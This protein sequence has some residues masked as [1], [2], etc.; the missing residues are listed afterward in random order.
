MIYIDLPINH[1]DF[2]SYVK[3]PGGTVSKKNELQFIDCVR[4]ASLCYKRL[5]VLA[6]SYVFPEGTK[7]GTFLIS[8]SFAGFPK[9]SRRHDNTRSYISLL[10]KLEGRS[11]CP[12]SHYFIS[13]RCRLFEGG[14]IPP[15]LIC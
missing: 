3:T 14:A 6:M 1:C 10:R 13:F 8:T 11:W 4:S 7:I 2:H 9:L 15:P 5:C 12:V